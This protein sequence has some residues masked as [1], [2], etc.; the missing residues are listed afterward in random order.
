MHGCGEYKRAHSVEAIAVISSHVS[1]LLNTRNETFFNVK[2]SIQT[3]TQR[4]NSSKLFTDPTV[5]AGR[6]SEDS[7][8]ADKVDF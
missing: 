5:T 7:Y 8:P 6:T 3:R 2:S 1:R 4:K